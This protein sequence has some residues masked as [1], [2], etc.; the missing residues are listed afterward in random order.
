MKNNKKGFSL[1]EVL[2]ALTIAAIVAIFGFSIAK[3]GIAKAYDRY[4]YAGYYAI[5]IAL[6]DDADTR[7]LSMQDAGCSG[8][9]SD[10]N[11]CSF[12]VEP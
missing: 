10:T 2:I 9:L 5:S 6:S 4:I 11:S 3:K 1:A 12:S 7:G 8:S